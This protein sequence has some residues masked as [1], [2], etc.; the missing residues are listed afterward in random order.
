MSWA[1]ANEWN[2]PIA[3]EIARDIST[4]S[5]LYCGPAAVGWIAAVWNNSKGRTYEY[6]KR[7]KDKDLFPDGPRPFHTDLPGFQTNL[8]DTLRRETN[9][10]LRLAREIYFRYGTL[11]W[12]RFNFPGSI[13]KWRQAACDIIWVSKYC[14]MFNFQPFGDASWKRISNKSSS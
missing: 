12:W 5:G 3:K 6:K 4:I 7:L 14:Y 9:N 13:Q 10:E 1:L 2:S 8:S 11:A